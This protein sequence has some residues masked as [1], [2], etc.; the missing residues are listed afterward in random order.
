MFATEYPA[1]DGYLLTARGNP[2]GNVVDKV[3]R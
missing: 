3:T 2:F 1:E